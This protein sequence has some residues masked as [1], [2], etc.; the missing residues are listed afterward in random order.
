MFFLDLPLFRENCQLILPFLVVT[1]KLASVSIL[2]STYVTKEIYNLFNYLCVRFS[3]LSSLIYV[4]HLTV[5]ELSLTEG[6][7]SHRELEI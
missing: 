2:F 4:F 1:F 5:L 7:V 6:F 3:L